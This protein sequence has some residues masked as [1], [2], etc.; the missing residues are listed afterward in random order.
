M[1]DGLLGICSGCGWVDSRG[2]RHE[3]GAPRQ[4]TR[5]L[6]NDRLRAIETTALLVRQRQLEFFVG[7]VEDSFRV[8]LRQGDVHQIRIG[9][10]IG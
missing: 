10:R 8:V 1:V 2:P 9:V 7:M 4:G 6:I 3:R 5:C